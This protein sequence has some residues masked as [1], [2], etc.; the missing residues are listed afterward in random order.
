[1]PSQAG[2]STFAQHIS[3]KILIFLKCWPPKSLEKEKQPTIDMNIVANDRISEAAQ[4]TYQFVPFSTNS[5]GEQPLSRLS[6]DELEAFL[7]A[8]SENAH[9]AHFF[10]AP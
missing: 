6:R 7:K 10:T 8:E 9:S 3:K 4:F 1:M 2:A 5:G